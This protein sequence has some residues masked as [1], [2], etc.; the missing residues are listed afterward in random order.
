MTCTL[1][2]PRGAD[3]AYAYAFPASLDVSSYTARLVIYESR[4]GAVL[5]T[6][7]DAPTAN[8]SS[9]VFDGQ[10]L[11]VY[12][13]SD[14]IDNLPE[15]ADP[16][17]P[18]VLQYDL[19]LTS[20]D[21]TEKLTGGPFVVMPLGSGLC[22]CDGDGG[23][24]LTVT[25]GDCTATVELVGPRGASGIGVPVSN[26]VVSSGLLAASDQQALWA[27]TGGDIKT[28][29]P[30]Q[31]SE[32]NGW[33]TGDDN[34][35]AVQATFDAC[36]DDGR[37]PE[38]LSAAIFGRYYLGDEVPLVVDPSRLGLHCLGGG[39][40]D[41]RNKTYL[42]PAAQTELLSDPGFNTG[43]P[44]IISPNDTGQTV[45]GGELNH[46]P[47]AGIQDYLERGALIPV[48]AG[49]T[50]RVTMV[51]EEIT[52]HI[53]A[54]TPFRDIGVS[55]RR[56]TGTGPGSIGSGPNVGGSTW[57]YSNNTAGYAPGVT[58]SRDFT[59]SEA[60][61]YVRIQSNAK[62][63]VSSWSV[64]VVP[65]NTILRLTVPPGSAGGQLRGHNYRD[66][67]NF[68]IA[69][70]P[71]DESA[72]VIATTWDTPVY[73]TGDLGQHSRGNWYNVDIS[74]GVGVGLDLRNR[75][76]LSNYYGCR[77]V[78]SKR[79]VQTMA[80]AL[81]AGENIT[82]FGG[83][84]GGGEVGVSN[85]GNFEIHMISTSIDFS[86]QWYVGGG[87]FSMIAGHL[88]TNA[89]TVA[90]YPLIDV[91]VGHCHIQAKL[92]VNGSTT[93]VLDYPFRVAKGGFLNIEAETPYNLHGTA[94]A[95]CTGEG[96][97]RMVARGGTSREMD[98]ITKRDDVHNLFGVGG[99]F[100]TDEIEI[101]AWVG[102]GAAHQQTSPHQIEFG[103]ASSFTAD[104]AQGSRVLVNTSISPSG[105]Q[106]QAKISDG[107][108]SGSRV[109]G[110]QNAGSFTGNTTISSN[111]ITGVSPAPTSTTAGGGR[112]YVS[113][114]GI[115]IGAYI[116]SYSNA[117]ATLT[118]SEQVAST[119][120]GITISTS[121]IVLL[122]QPWEGEGGTGLTV[123]YV[124][125]NPAVAGIEISTAQSRSGTK[126]LRL[127]K[128]A[129]VGTSN[130]GVT[131]A[132]PLSAHRAT[133]SEFWW[134]IPAGG[135]GTTSIFFTSRF[136]RLTL[137][138]PWPII[139]PGSQAITDQPQ[140]GISLSTGVP[141]TRASFGTHRVD[142]SSAHD[143][144]MPEGCTHVLWDINLSSAPSNFEMFIADLCASEA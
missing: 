81:D 129:G 75:T 65:N 16:T 68:K 131:L 132:Y 39:I 32:W 9:I 108:A 128:G 120:T 107:S 56:N 42:D 24:D 28:W 50:L 27:I 134:M 103:S 80:G 118:L 30:E 31:F 12:V 83:N 37:V 44:L 111:V 21:L 61:P 4:G 144:Y 10:R 55:F 11:E 87:G 114:P 40:L 142:P 23:G 105:T 7:T 86:R 19:F 18:S 34:S 136:A 74:D 17:S 127:Y 112:K 45:Y 5:L 67:R 2:A 94:E 90:G 88:E 123:P 135:T 84:M 133:G 53:P 115:P 14:D 43:A 36:L 13:E 33:G 79:C 41:G 106:D 139:A 125:K 93:P 63:R 49:T 91:T 15:D 52:T 6:I 62:V 102:S 110:Y 73:P 126:S 51:V 66:W 98:A 29:R 77:I 57:F 99:S 104:A 96:R 113:G 76:Y 95:L 82:F 71:G 3:L 138:G 48:A 8:G 69:G 119:A 101:L 97:F 35:A 121:N 25:L 117:S 26:Y 47:R 137:G 1:T 60:N 109:A 54:S 85:E 130:F 92:Q 58:V 141:W 70:K 116:M 59:I 89:P 20:V 140:T 64:K 122:S 22:G 78:T 38:L 72:F 100:E 46:T 143:G 124:L